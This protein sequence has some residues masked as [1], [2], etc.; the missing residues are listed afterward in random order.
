MVFFV[1][2]MVRVIR[3][4]LIA[5]DDVPSFIHGTAMTRES[6]GIL[7]DTRPNL[8]MLCRSACPRQLSMLFF[9]RIPE[10]WPFTDVCRISLPHR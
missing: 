9:A 10:A 8:N 3:D 5:S 7:D 1:M 6:L 2:A 4:D